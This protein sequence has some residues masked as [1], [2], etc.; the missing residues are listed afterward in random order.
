[1][2]REQWVKSQG[3]EAGLGDQKM[4]TAAAR[5]LLEAENLQ[6][7]ECLTRAVAEAAAGTSWLS[8]PNLFTSPRRHYH[9]SILGRRRVPPSLWAI[10]SITGIPTLL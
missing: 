4:Q 3:T 9:K 1:M 10:C 5:A 8:L 6:N 2:S 7:G